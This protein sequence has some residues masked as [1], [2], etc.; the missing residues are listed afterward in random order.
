MLDNCIRPQNPRAKRLRVI[1]SRGFPKGSE[2]MPPSELTTQPAASA[3]VSSCW[4]VCSQAKNKQLNF[5]KSLLTRLQNGNNEDSLLN[6]WGSMQNENVK[7]KKTQNKNNKGF[8]TRGWV[9]H[10]TKYVVV[11]SGD[12]SNWMGLMSVNLALETRRSKTR[13]VG[14]KWLQTFT[15]PVPSIA[16]VSGTQSWLLHWSP[17]SLHQLVWPKFLPWHWQNWVIFQ[18]SLQL[19]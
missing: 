14:A 9:E 5:L 11:L 12:I 19:L 17:V 7:N 15:A 2:I 8:Q 1:V 4:D 6:L 18:K 16:Q 13:T 10:E 3:P